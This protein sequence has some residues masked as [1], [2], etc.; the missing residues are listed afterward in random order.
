M[1]VLVERARIAEVMP[2]S[3]YRPR[4]GDRLVDLGDVTL[5]PGLIDAHV[6]LSIG[7]PPRAA[8]AATLEAGF[9]TVADLG[10]VSQ[11]IHL[12]PD[13]IA[14][15]AWAGPRVLTAGLWIGVKDGVCEFGGIGVSG[16]A[17]A[18]RARVRENI[19]AGANLIKAC[20]TG[21][22]AVAWA[23]PDSA[24]L[25]SAMLA[26][27]VDEAHR[28]GRRVVAHALSRAGVGRALEARVDGLA[29]AALV[30]DSLAGRM[31]E[32][33]MWLIP[34]LASLTA[35][36]SSAPARALRDAVCRAHEAGVM[37]VYGTDGGVLPHGRNAEEALALR[38]AGIPAVDVLRAATINAARALG[39]ADSVGAIS[40]GMIA[41]LVAFPGDPLTDVGVLRQPRFVMA[42]GRIVL[43]DTR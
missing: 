13:S 14:A 29:H 6:H 7:G 31:Q 34:T 9:T 20:V 21:W 16:G 10:A 1:L 2:A 24:E 32:R 25:S 41:D 33:G 37:L 22:P 27:L 35:G 15:G 4:P 19:A 5:S 23:H 39:I 12:V 40:P 18:F 3:R 11:G 8:A 42:R 36:D 28:A 17:D 26:A 30:D 38:A 43:G